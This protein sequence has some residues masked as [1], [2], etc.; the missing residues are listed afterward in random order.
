M[1][2]EA[3]RLNSGLMTGAWLA[4][5][6]IVGEASVVWPPVLFAND[7]VFATP[8]SLTLK[9]LARVTTPQMRVGC[10]ALYVQSGVSLA[11]YREG[12]PF[13]GDSDIDIRVVISSDCATNIA[14]AF[15]TQLSK[16]R[17]R[18]TKVSLNYFSTWGDP[19]TNLAQHAGPINS[20]RVKAL[21]S[22]LT[23]APLDSRNTT[24]FFIRKPP[25]LLQDLRREYGPAWFVPSKN[26][27]LTTKA[28]QRGTKD[29]A[30]EGFICGHQNPAPHSVDAW[31]AR[32]K[33]RSD[34]YAT[35]SQAERCRANMWFAWV[36]DFCNG[37]ATFPRDYT[38]KFPSGSRAWAFPECG[39]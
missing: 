11:K 36:R 15:R 16:C 34:G 17:Q 27:G 24:S 19:I 2:P 28:L 5:W 8:D 1:C 10:A 4:F 6:A 12:G 31:M 30:V 23:V 33:V 35:I 22:T 29:K 13:K 37:A 20:T 39:I 32:H 38:G 3:S 7:N 14:S 25:L 18:G 26:H 21:L 9:C